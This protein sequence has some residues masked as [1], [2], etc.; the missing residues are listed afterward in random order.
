MSFSVDD[1]SVDSGGGG[2][3]T[4][5]VG[6]PVGFCDAAFRAIARRFRAGNWGR[7]YVGGKEGKGCSPEYIRG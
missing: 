7:S 3:D 2:P 5:P 6:F 1:V 4:E